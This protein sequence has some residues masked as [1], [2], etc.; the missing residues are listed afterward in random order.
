MNFLEF[1]CKRLNYVIVEHFKSFSPPETSGKNYRLLTPAVSIIV[2]KISFLERGFS[3]VSCKVQHG[4]VGGSITNIIVARNFSFCHHFGFDS[5]HSIVVAFKKKNR[6]KMGFTENSL[7]CLKY[8]KSLSACRIH[9]DDM[10][11]K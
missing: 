1:V 5:S 7:W 9:R 8:N 10:G 3:F 4:I 6:N 2:T 11:M